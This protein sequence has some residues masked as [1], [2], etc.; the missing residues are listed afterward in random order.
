MSGIQ[1]VLNQ[2]KP[3]AQQSYL[4]ISLGS[5]KILLD[6]FHSES[7]NAACLSGPAHGRGSEGVMVTR[8]GGEQ[9]FQ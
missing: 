2:C 3:L 7:P 8:V 4:G 1:E 5:L 9:T 6:N